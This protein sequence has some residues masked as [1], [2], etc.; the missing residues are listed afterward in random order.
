ML[1]NSSPLL[2]QN[3]PD[4]V[5]HKHTNAKYIPNVFQLLSGPG[6]GTGWHGAGRI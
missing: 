6:A 1:K 2:L 3:S 4:T 5:R